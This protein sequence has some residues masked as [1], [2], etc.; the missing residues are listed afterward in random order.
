MIDLDLILRHPNF[1]LSAQVSLP[2]RG[3]TGLVGPSGSGKTSLL[4]S[5]AGLNTP[6]QGTIRFN[7][8]TW[9]D[10]TGVNLSPQSRPV[11]VVFQDMRLFPHL[12]IE[13]NLTQAAIWGKAPPLTTEIIDALEL[14]PLLHRYPQALSGGEARR[15]ALARAL[16][17]SPKLL[18][19]DEPLAGLDT[20]QKDRILPYIARALHAANLPAIFVSHD[21]EEVARLCPKTVTLAP[22]TSDTRSF[23]ISQPA[24]SGL[25]IPARVQDTDA[26]SVTLAV[27]DQ[28]ITSTPVLPFEQGAGVTIQ[29]LPQTLMF[30]GE[31]FASPLDYASLKVSVREAGVFADET[32]IFEAGSQEHEQIAELAKQAGARDG[33]GWL[34]FRVIAVFADD[35]G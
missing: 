19:L 8:Q 9:F 25:Q 20:G 7:G 11:A 4:R 16:A 22:E 3:I 18:L 27:G 10:D 30:G 26:H 12:T 14:A 32:M 23:T 17:Q 34:Y 33:V 29:T 31:S 13:G 35:S 15:V 28:R 21:A 1:Q 6:E 5:I 2:D 24:A